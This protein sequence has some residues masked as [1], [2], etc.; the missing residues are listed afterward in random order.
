MPSHCFFLIIHTHILKPIPIKVKGVHNRRINVMQPACS[1]IGIDRLHP[2]MGF[3]VRFK[4]VA[5]WLN[6]ATQPLCHTS[7]YCF[8]WYTPCPFPLPAPYTISTAS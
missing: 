6:A 8:S 5:T 2:I 4:M 1:G 7:R 3:V